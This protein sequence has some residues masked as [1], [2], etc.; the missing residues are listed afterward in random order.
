M[1]ARDPFR[2][3]LLP[4]IPAGTELI[5]ANQDGARPAGLYFT[6]RFDG[7]VRRTPAIIGQLN[8]AGVREVNAHRA[9]SLEVQAFGAGSY[10]ALDVLGQ[11]LAHDESLSRAESLNLAIGPMGA[12]TDEPALRDNHQWE[13][14]AIAALP[15]AYTLTTQ[16]ELSWIETVEGTI[17]VDGATAL[18]AF[19]EPYSAT[20]VET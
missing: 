4:L 10:D 20:I 7:V 14:R 3:L 15:F 18:P 1:A 5:W 6:M 16:E 19:S 13:P 12:V 9:G 11:Q 2:T 8:D 17:T